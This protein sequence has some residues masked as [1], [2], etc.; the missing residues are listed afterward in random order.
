MRPRFHIFDRLDDFMVVG[1]LD[2]TNINPRTGRVM[3]DS[4]HWYKARCTCGTLAY[5]SQQE[6]R[7]NRRTRACTSCLV[8]ERKH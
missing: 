1:H 6:L 4:Q 5:R 8:N 7:D 2:P 3:V